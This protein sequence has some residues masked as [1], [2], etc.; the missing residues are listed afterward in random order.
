[1][2]TPYA[3]DSLSCFLAAQWGAAA[4]LI[5]LI[6][7]ARLPIAS[8]LALMAAVGL[9]GLA[10]S[11][12]PMLDS[13][14]HAVGPEFFRKALEL[15]VALAALGAL[16]ALRPLVCGL[17]LLSL[18]PIWKV[19]GYVADS[20]AELAALTMAWIGLLVG[21]LARRPGR[22]DPRPIS[23]DAEGSYVLHDAVLF[24]AATM[25]AAL[26]SW[27]VM[28]RRDG[29]ADEWA[30]TFQASVFAKGRAYAE[31]PRCQNFLESFYVYES[32]GR[33]FSMYT[34]GWPIV[35]VPFVWAR[36]V[37]M[38]G[39]FSMG[40]MAWG[41]AR[42]GR[43]AMR[44]FGAG[45][46]MPSPALVRASGTWAAVVAMLG[47]TILEN[48]GSRYAH[49][50]MT[51][52]YA[53]SLEGLLMASSAG[54]SKRRQL[55]WGAVFGSG[56]AMMLATRPAEGAFLGLG[57]AVL[58]VYTSA[59]LRFPWRALLAA[60]AGFAF[61]SFLTLAI[62]R[63]QLGKWFVTGYSLMP[64]LQPWQAVKYS[65]PKPNEWKYGI[66][67]ATGAYCW[68]PCSLPLGL[69]GVAM[70]RGRARGLAVAF[71]IGTL[72]LIAYLSYLELGR[73]YDWGYGP[74]YLMVLLVPMA[75]GTG[76]ALASFTATARER[77]SG[78]GLTAF[79]RGTPLG[80]ALLAMATSWLRIVPSLWPP[81]YQHTHRHSAVNRAIEEQHLTN[82][83]VI[84][85][86]GTT[87]FSEADLTTNLPLDLYPNPDVIIGVERH[88]GDAAHTCLRSGYPGR[89][90]YEASGYDDVKLTPIP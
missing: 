32:S 54:L 8:K 3:V 31:A 45:E 55:L 88:L 81:V 76:V 18:W 58:F 53:W 52:L 84:A 59:R 72:P 29:S 14:G 56:C 62:L 87:G 89:R 61:W 6:L 12:G 27:Y 85:A 82:A 66:P 41:M 23:P 74:R 70:L 40:F 71:A 33:L 10:P 28:D 39:P 11:L 46:A 24:A 68:W 51:G 22:Y 83:V 19:S 17:A 2:H 90:L 69:A 30:Y 4:L 78:A 7:F 57:V 43:T 15:S 38:S 67:L 75:I 20:D 48:G 49:V 73:G 36:S 13:V 26:F 21:V 63:L 79:S 9:A 1:V 35:M 44:Q 77:M 42:L 34:P 64:M 5:A 65:W 60:T 16:L 37:W 47:T 50:F 80:I 25:L 86:D